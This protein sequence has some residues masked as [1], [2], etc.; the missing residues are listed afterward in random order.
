VTDTPK[1]GRGNPNGNPGNKG[2]KGKPTLRKQGR[3]LVFRPYEDTEDWVAE[4][5]RA[6]YIRSLI[7]WH[8]RNPAVVLDPGDLIA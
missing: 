3:P 1:K 2:G 4:R 5:G 8:R 6:D 7:D